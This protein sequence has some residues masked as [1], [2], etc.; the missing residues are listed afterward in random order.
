[1]K[2]N[3]KEKQS[4]KLWDVIFT[5]GLLSLF[6]ESQDAQSDEKKFKQLIIQSLFDFSYSSVILNRL[7]V[8]Y[9]GGCR[10]TYPYKTHH[11]KSETGR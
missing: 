11:M 3:N 4:W 7:L 8:S 1:M 6:K 9:L 2:K 5:S 10:I